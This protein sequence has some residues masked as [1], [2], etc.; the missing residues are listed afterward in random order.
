MAFARTRCKP[1]WLF[2]PPIRRITHS[3]C[4][5]LFLVIQQR[6]VPASDTTMSKSTSGKYSNISIPGPS[7]TYNPY[8]QLLVDGL[9][10]RG[11]EVVDATIVN[12]LRRRVVL[13]MHFPDHCVT[14]GR[15]HD[16]IFRTAQH[17]CLYAIVLLRG[18]KIVWFVHDVHPLQP[19]RRRLLNAYMAL[20]RKVIHA[21]VFLSRTSRR[22]FHLDFP[23]SRKL[24][25]LLL[26]HGPYPTHS[27]PEDRYA[28]RR[29]L[30]VEENDVLIG[31]LGSI[32]T[33]KNVGTLAALPTTAN[34]R[35]VTLLLAGEID[36]E[37]CADV[38]TLKKRL[39]DRLR[40]FDR[41]LSDLHFEHAIRACDVV[42]IPYRDGYNS[43]A[44]LHALS[45]GT[46]ILTSALP[47][48][49]ELKEDFGQAW[50]RPYAADD[51]M[52]RELESLLQSPPT[53][54]DRAALHSRL[55]E[56]SFTTAGAA[57]FA[58]TSGLFRKRSRED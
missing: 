45:C 46:P 8:F 23:T 50:V 47:I 13:L 44:A 11:A 37:S 41:R 56:R 36:A 17:L 32:K 5:P 20:F 52:G 54:S 26:Y 10:Q 39:G 40:C 18:G 35:N 14:D 2:R 49:A 22:R 53:E 51:D 29:Q 25:E 42:M 31:F 1:G 27:K 24:P 15:L 38:V 3:T 58:F 9:R 33:Y 28:F 12:L 6:H 34:G 48:F 30:R 19:K 21:R 4:S 57:L 7:F 43:G 55:E 16:A